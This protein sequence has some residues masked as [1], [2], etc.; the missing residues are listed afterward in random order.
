MMLITGSTCLFVEVREITMVLVELCGFDH[1]YNDLYTS[2]SK[3]E[4]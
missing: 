4:V 1:K 2:V 3:Y